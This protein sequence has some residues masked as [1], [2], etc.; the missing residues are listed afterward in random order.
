M[1]L[2]PT[3][4]II[5]VTISTQ[6][7]IFKSEKQRRAEIVEAVHALLAPGEGK[8][9]ILVHSFSN[10]G[11]KRSY[12]VAGVYQS[13][14]GKTFA[15]KTLI[16]D[17]APG[18]PQFRR[19]VHAIA[20]PARKLGFFSRLLFITVTYVLAAVVQVSVY[21][22][23]LGFWYNLVWGPM[24]G[25]KNPEILDA[26]TV[27]GFV[28]SKEDKAIDWRDVER[29]SDSAKENGYKVER[30]L[31]EGAEHA[32]MFRGKGGEKDYWSWVEKMWSLGM[33]VG[34]K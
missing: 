13:L 19:D 26:K 21:R 9:R 12:N 8:D 27:M 11:G 31:I 3:A 20:V 7:F 5:V 10:G 33:A 24:L 30:K 34:E 1:S 15:P 18:M 17:S 25:L 28:Y 23:P 2:Y 22:M 6:Q 29:W 4:Q 32:Q 16:F 14:T